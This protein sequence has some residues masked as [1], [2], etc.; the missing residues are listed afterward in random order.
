MAREN[1]DKTSSW[2][3]SAVDR[4]RLA[5]RR[6]RSRIGWNATAIT[7]VAATDSNRLG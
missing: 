7:P 5:S 3:R 2:C 6:L 4:S 1:V